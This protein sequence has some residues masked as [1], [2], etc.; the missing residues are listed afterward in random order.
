MVYAMDTSDV[1]ALDA[2]K[3]EVLWK[4]TLGE[5]TWRPSINKSGTTIYIITK[6]YQLY[7]V[8]TSDGTVLWNL[9]DVSFPVVHPPTEPSKLYVTTAGSI[10]EISAV[11]GSK[12]VC[13]PF[14]GAA[15]GRDA[16]KNTFFVGILNNENPKGPAT[17]AAIDD[18]NGAKQIWAVTSQIGG[19][20]IVSPDGKEIYFM[21]YT[22][23][24]LRSI[25][26][27][28]GKESWSY[29]GS[30]KWA[31][32][33]LSNDNNILYTAYAGNGQTTFLAFDISSTSDRRKSVRGLAHVAIQE[34]GSIVV[35]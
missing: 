32:L 15:I 13:I 7:A 16:E 23:S 8:R 6:T 20:P 29:P 25:N 21:D 1:W 2:A 34:E 27:A 19:R 30:G 10:C 4:S 18:K 5:K 31:G 12:N 28:D 11:D 14:K 17:I 26:T 9:A 3:G 35:D 24:S 33:A 22:T